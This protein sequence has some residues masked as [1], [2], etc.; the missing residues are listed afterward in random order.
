MDW[1]LYDRDLPHER[2]K[3]ST[4]SKKGHS[5]VSLSELILKILSN[6]VLKQSED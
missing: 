5:K 4:T 2:V 1:F 3:A 6:P